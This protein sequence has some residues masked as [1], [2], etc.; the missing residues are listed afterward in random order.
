LSDPHGIVGTP[1]QAWQRKGDGLMPV[2]GG[3]GAD[4]EGSGNRELMLRFCSLGNN[5]EVAAAQRA[6]G[7]EPNDLFRWAGVDASVVLKLLNSRF[8]GIGEPGKIN[9]GERLPDGQHMA[10]HSDGFMWH[11]WM[12]S[13]PVSRDVLHSRECKRLPFLA[14]KLIEEMTEAVRIFV[15]KPSDWHPMTCADAAALSDAICAYGRS[16]LMFVHDGAARPSVERVSRYLLHGVITRF[17]D[18]ENVIHTT[19]AEEWR[20]LFSE[21]ARMAVA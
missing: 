20:Q 12:S 1:V 16:T 15:I 11:A 21:A 19:D 4:A 18:T 2:S 10:T 6:F 13:E 7:A 8:V 14:G 17:A 3:H 9:I 5:C